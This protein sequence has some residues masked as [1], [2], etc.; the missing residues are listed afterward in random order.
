[1]L[2]QF[3]LIGFPLSHSFSPGYFSD[4]F[5]AGRIHAEYKAYPLASLDEFP[6]LLERVKPQ[7]LNVTIPYKEKILGYLHSLDETAAAIG[8]V[9]TI[10]ITNNRL[11]GFNTDA[12]AFQQTLRIW[13]GEP[14]KI[15]GALVLGSGGAS[16]AV[17]YALHKE[18]IPFL[19]VSRSRKGD[20]SYSDID[21]NILTQNNLIINTTPLGMA[22]EIAACPP[23]PYDALD[24]NNF[25]YDLIYNPEKTLFLTEGLRRGACIKNGKDMLL[26][27][28]ELAWQIWNQPVM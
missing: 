9:N 27:Q 11:T 3:G 22:P 14:Q 24:E 21:K 17:R 8:A 16:L 12:P 28:A 4:K 7:G 6:D 5:T 13:I 18:G 10:R 25:L 26:L 1:M 19:V 23:L 15:R 2:R 20:L